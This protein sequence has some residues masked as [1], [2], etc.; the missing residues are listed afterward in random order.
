M[1]VEQVFHAQSGT[2]HGARPPHPL[3][4][5]AQTASS[6][7]A[8]TRPTFSSSS[9]AHALDTPSIVPNHAKAG[10][11]KR[12]IRT[13]PPP[14][15]QSAPSP[16][17]ADTSRLA[18]DIL[19]SLGRPAA[20]SPA[21]EKSPP[22]SLGETPEAKRKRAT[23]S[24]LSPV[25]K[26]RT[27]EI[28]DHP[29]IV[30]EIMTPAVLQETRESQ[31]ADI[32]MKLEEII[33]TNAI[34]MPTQSQ[35][36][37][38]PPAESVASGPSTSS[39]ASPAHEVIDLAPDVTE[40]AAA[41][42]VEM[43]NREQDQRELTYV[44]L[45]ASP[46]RASSPPAPVQHVALS[47]LRS[48]T[49]DE[50]ANERP[51]L[52]LPSSSA[53][54]RG[55]APFEAREGR[56][57]VDSD[58]AGDGFVLNTDLLRVVP[59]S[60]ASA[61]AGPSKVRAKKR[62]VL[63][64]EEDLPMSA[65][66]RKAESRKAVIDF[67][68]VP[69]LPEWAKRMNARE[70]E[71]ELPSQRTSPVAESDVVLISDDEE[72][73]ERKAQEAQEQQIAELSYSRLREMPCRWRGCDAVLNSANN[74]GQ[75]TP[76]HVENDKTNYTCDWQGCATTF[77]RKDVFMRH[78]RSHAFLPM[79]CAYEGCDRSFA[80][81]KDLLQH[82]SSYRHRG[83]TVKPSTAPFVRADLE[84]APPM[85]AVLPA[86]M[87]VPRRITRH[88]I[89][90][91]THAWLKSKVLE[92]ITCF[93]F[94][95]RR[96]K[97]APPTRSV[98]LGEKDAADEENEPVPILELWRRRAQDEYEHFAREQTRRAPPPC[99]AIPSAEVTHMCERGLTILPPPADDDEGEAVV[100]VP[101]ADKA[102]ATDAGDAT[103]VGNAADASNA[104]A[105][106]DIDVELD[107][108]AQDDAAMPQMPEL[109]G[110]LVGGGVEGEAQSGNG[111][112]DDSSVV[113]AGDGAWLTQ[114]RGH[115]EQSQPGWTVLPQEEDKEK[116]DMHL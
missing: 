101:G 73:R 3:A 7:T 107:E 38:L 63:S 56:D 99:G 30:E 82:H 17:K 81:A 58:A 11:S 31:A 89:P 92:N 42:F 78:L 76:G 90:K 43:F 47:S 39:A 115:E 109:A 46:V 114:S 94:K 5:Q 45:N 8:T 12:D 25:K 51:P 16:A 18:R 21:R 60:S 32:G 4:H 111:N 23:E 66:K 112:S 85:P 74:L 49:P 75:H 50:A 41:Q 97:A 1:L 69:P 57:S 33:Q 26:M 27:M 84:P 37:P 48:P 34:P 55:D 88:P 19:R 95:G 22:P 116:V 105:A 28:V 52:F 96:S 77:A 86:Y 79:L 40:E 53:S 15:L 44:S 104:V 59:D 91:A 54:S 67:V 98:Q 24:P 113:M 83:A 62:A 100:Q 70:K 102:G 14:P 87:A 64:D 2:G 72:E 9:I 65:R 13:P 36:R 29:D 10:L 35:P 20:V 110:E 103:A 106:M 108:L 61:E 6:S 93:Y 68:A 71:L 80:T